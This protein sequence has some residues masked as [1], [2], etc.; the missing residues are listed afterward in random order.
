MIIAISLYL[1]S[2]SGNNYWHN[3]YEDLLSQYNT[4]MTDY[5]GM[6]SQYNSLETN[7]TTLKSQY[8]SLYNQYQSL[9]SQYTNLQSQYN[10][11]QSQ[12]TTLESNYTALKVNYN[13]LQNQYSSM[14]SQYNALETNYTNLQNQYNSLY[15][16]YNGILNWLGS[17][18]GSGN[19][20]PSA[21][22]IPVIVIIPSGFSGTV[23]LTVSSS[24]NS[25]EVFVVDT[26]NLI[27][28]VEGQSP[29][30]YLSAF[31]M[32]INKQITL[33]SGVYYVIVYNP[34]NASSVYFSINVV[35]T[36]S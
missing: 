19:L 34:S 11:L 32:Y 7:Y 12:Y 18:S 8:N 35:T 1:S 15:N 14:Q 33:G 2:A 9:Q 27:Y 29:T 25:V 36:Y 26:A 13:S 23:S 5:S 17:G 31:G 4:L 10:A 16:T 20:G 3:K 28:F 22:A 24:P 30:Y 21:F 6:Q